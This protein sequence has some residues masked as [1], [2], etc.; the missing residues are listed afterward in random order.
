MEELIN[1]MTIEQIVELIERIDEGDL[2][3]AGSPAFIGENTEERIDDICDYFGGYKLLSAI[4]DSPCGRYDPK[5]K[6]VICDTDLGCVFSFSDKQ[7][8]FNNF[9]PE[10]ILADEFR[11]RGIELKITYEITD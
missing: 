9:L 10:T 1:L 5:D 3:K 7:T 4:F 8:L 6:W 11:D 2:S